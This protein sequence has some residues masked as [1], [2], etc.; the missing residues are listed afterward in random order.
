MSKAPA[1]QFYPKD[2]LSSPKVQLM[3]PAQEGAYIR[4]LAYCWD[5]G[6]CSLPDD[7]AELAV[8]SRLGEGWFNGGSAIVRR[9]FVPHPTKPGHLSNPRL[10]DE[11]A[12][13]AAWQ[14]KSS[15]GGK[16][17]AAK[18]AEIKALSKG[19]STTPQPAAGRPVQPPGSSSPPSASATRTEDDDAR[20]GVSGPFERVYEYGCAL[21]PQLATQNTSPIHQWLDSGAD[22]DRDILP[23]IKRVH[24]KQ[25]RP[26]GWGLFTQDVASAKLRRT[27]PLPKGEPRHARPASRHARFADQDYASGTDGFVTS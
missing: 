11:A 22:V 3:T 1:F 25:V 16:K 12:K 20:A 10:L 13:Q 26:K 18:R 14:R 6:D 27:T 15:E 8:L 21:F 2:W 7:D 23:E 9:C 17:S 5:S 19:G 24:D 4:L